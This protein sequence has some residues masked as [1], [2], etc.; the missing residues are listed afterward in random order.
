MASLTPPISRPVVLYA[1]QTLDAV[2]AEFAATSGT[3]ASHDEAVER[4]ADVRRKLAGELWGDCNHLLVPVDESDLSDDAPRR[5]TV[6][7][8]RFDPAD[9]DSTEL[10]KERA[11]GEAEDEFTKGEAMPLVRHRDGLVTF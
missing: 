1:V 10:A 3:A 9:L 4:V 11:R 8:K 2:L 6:C 5:C 7:G